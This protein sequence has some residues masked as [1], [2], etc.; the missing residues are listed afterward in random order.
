[1]RNK[2]DRLKR[3]L[4]PTAWVKAET[5]VTK[6]KS[7]LEKVNTN[8]LSQVD[9]LLSLAENLLG[10][11]DE[12]VVAA[13]T[14][15]NAIKEGIDACVTLFEADNPIQAYADLGTVKRLCVE[16]SKSLQKA[17]KSCELFSD[18]G[19]G[20]TQTWPVYVNDLSRKIIAD[21]YRDVNNNLVGKISVDIQL[22][23]PNDIFIEILAS[24]VYTQ[25][26]QGAAS[27]VVDEICSIGTARLEAIDT[28]IETNEQESIDAAKTN[29]NSWV[30][31]TNNTI[32]SKIRHSIDTQIELSA[33]RLSKAKKHG[34][35][36]KLKIGVTLVRIGVGIAGLGTALTT[37]GATAGFAVWSFY[38]L[39]V[40]LGVQMANMTAEA[41]DVYR[42]AL[43]MLE[44][45]QTKYSNISS[46]FRGTA[47]EVGSELL[48]T[49]VKDKFFSGLGAVKDEIA[50]AGNLYR[51][52]YA[53]IRNE[54]EPQLNELLKQIDTVNTE[55]ADLNESCGD[56]IWK[57]LS[58][59][60]GKAKQ[61]IQKLLT[62][63]STDMAK[64]NNRIPMLTEKT[65]QIT[66]LISQKTQVKF[67][68]VTGKLLLVPS[69]L[70]GS[71]AK[72]FETE[73]WPW[74]EAEAGFQQLQAVFA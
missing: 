10:I 28:A 8:Y 70:S 46:K 52:L 48:K 57:A 61:D 36:S 16:L 6:Y 26:I 5:N 55:T 49:L 69:R 20:G 24:Q 30:E 40:L 2:F 21:G 34:V 32:E 14:E 9:I 22:I 4:D 60:R 68:M 1:M 66:E 29:Y 74:D 31:D 63:I 19:G 56:K 43:G 7:R 47:E 42:H 59:L 13:N 54:M 33:Q 65:E 64:I 51:V 25:E 37:G 11:R 3:T 62:S 72:G 41:D 27:R 73:K 71:L 15:Y 38:K 67:V 44:D 17:L 23:I 35:V 12:G 18:E 53:K 45:A 39:A 58:Y 50:L